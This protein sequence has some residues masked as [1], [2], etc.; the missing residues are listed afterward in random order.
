M[1]IMV[2]NCD[3]NYIKKILWKVRINEG[4]NILKSYDKGNLNKTLWKIT[5]KEK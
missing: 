3:K 2:E 4:G 1:K 5:I